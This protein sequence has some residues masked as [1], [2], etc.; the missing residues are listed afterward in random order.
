M[1]IWTLNSD[2]N[3]IMDGRV[4]EAV[5]IEIVG[6]DIRMDGDQFTLEPFNGLSYDGQAVYGDVQTE[7]VFQPKWP[8]D[9]TTPMVGNYE[10]SFITFGPTES[11]RPATADPAYGP[12]Y[13]EFWNVTEPPKTDVDGRDMRED[14]VGFRPTDYQISADA[15][16]FHGYHPQWGHIYFDGRF[17]STRVQTQYQY[18]RGGGDSSGFDKPAKADEPLIF[19]DLLVKGHIFRDVS[20]YIGWFD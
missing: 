12:I 13:V 16:S 6:Q 4:N 7:G 10:L 9:G 3:M 8:S 18:E 20:L 19:G 1:G 2:G 17:D 14:I 11:F 5:A 15:V